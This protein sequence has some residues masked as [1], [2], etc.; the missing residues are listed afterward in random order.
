VAAADIA[1]SA[2]AS[3]GLAAVLILLTGRH[4]RRESLLG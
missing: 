4:W 2:I 3:L 1:V